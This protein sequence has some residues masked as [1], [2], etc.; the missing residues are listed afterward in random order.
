MNTGSA[1]Q[2]AEGA[3]VPHGDGHPALT[4]VIVR[5]AIRQA[6]NGQDLVDQVLLGYGIPGDTIIPPVSISGAR[7]EPPPDVAIDWD[8]EAANSVLEDAGY[9]DTDGDGVR[10]MPEG[11]LE[12]GRPLEFRYFV[13]TNEQTSVDAAPFVSEWLGADRDRDQGA[14][15]HVRP[16]RGHHQRWRIRPVQL[17]LVSRIP[18]RTRPCRGSSATSGRR[19]GRPTAT[20]TRTTATPSTTAVPRAADRA[21]G[22]GALGDRPRDAAHLLRG[23]GVR[24]HVVRPAPAGV[25]L[26][27]VHRVQPAAA[28]GRRSAGGLWWSE[29]RLVPH[30]GPSAPAAAAGARGEARGIPAAVWLAI[31]GGADRRP[32]R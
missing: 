27:P 9:V 3:F 22:R 10:E 13:R 1:Y 18:T 24:G 31:A 25:S 5:R 8:L 20:T 19:T 16:A 29:R 17:G 15:G 2:E 4:D 14:P 21:D 30:S 11:S 12:P 6:I 32:R 28:A 7:F 26:G 23:R